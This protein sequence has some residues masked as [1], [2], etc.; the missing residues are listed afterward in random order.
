MVHKDT[1]EIQELYWRKLNFNSI[2]IFI[3][4]VYKGKAMLNTYI[5]SKLHGEF[6]FFFQYNSKHL[7]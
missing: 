4:S 6:P 1:I 3:G 7:H 5:L 2:L